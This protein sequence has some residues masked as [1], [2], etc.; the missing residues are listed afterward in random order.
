VTT[1][2][3]FVRRAHCET[4]APLAQWKTDSKMDD[5]MFNGEWLV[6]SIRR[7]VPQANTD[8]QEKLGEQLPESQEERSP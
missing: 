3:W 7:P 5:P 1:D 2:V 6:F 8:A 4:K